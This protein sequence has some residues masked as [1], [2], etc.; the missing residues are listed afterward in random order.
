MNADDA[1]QSTFFIV[2][3][4]NVWNKVDGGC[5]VALQINE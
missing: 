4:A 3:T 1:R 2:D 5:N